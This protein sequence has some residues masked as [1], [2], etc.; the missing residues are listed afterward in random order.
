MD[1]DFTRVDDCLTFFD[2]ETLDSDLDIFMS[3]LGLD[4]AIADKFAKINSLKINNE[5]VK[6]ES[7]TNKNIT[8][9]NENTSNIPSCNL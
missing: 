4:T 8:N 3:I 9:T 7:N 5:D 6:Q 2:N 1:F